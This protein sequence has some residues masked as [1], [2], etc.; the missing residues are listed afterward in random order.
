MELEK[1][2]KEYTLR[3]N[4]SDKFLYSKRI[5]LGG[6]THFIPNR[7]VFYISLAY[8]YYIFADLENIETN[9]ENLK[10]IKDIFNGYEIVL[11]QEEIGNSPHLSFANDRVV[12]DDYYQKFEYLYSRKIILMEEKLNPKSFCENIELF[13]TYLRMSKIINTNT[14]VDGEVKL[15]LKNKCS[16]KI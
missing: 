16:Y 6:F 1:I 15:L 11:T 8:S 10:K 12:Y 9:H 3:K 4:S 7:I 13:D 5:F 2:L 14:S